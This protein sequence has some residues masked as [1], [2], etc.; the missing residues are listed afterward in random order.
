MLEQRPK[1]AAIDTEDAEPGRAV[2]LDRDGTL[3]EDTHYVGSVEEVAFLPGAV[4]ALARLS[5]A[6][7]PLIIV[8]NQS[9]VARGYFPM[10][11]VH[12][13]HDHIQEE[14]ARHRVRIEEFLVCACHPDVGCDYRK[15]SPQL[16][17]E[18]AERRQLD[19]GQCYM[20]GDSAADV[21][22]GQAASVTSILVRTGKGAATEADPDVKPDRV[23]DD[24]AAAADWILSRSPSQSTRPTPGD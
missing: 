9:G 13:I 6:G 3:I 22:A 7:Y 15:P 2:F 21:G 10:E 1:E 14:L 23:D 12:A 4:A 18:A 20:I 11:T 5:E 19:L 8:T 24:L 16:L 17:L